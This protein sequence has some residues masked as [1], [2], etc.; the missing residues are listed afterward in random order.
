MNINQKENSSPP[1]SPDFHGFGTDSFFPKPL[2]IETEGVDDEEHVVNIFRRRKAGRPQEGWEKSG[3]IDGL[4]GRNILDEARR[5]PPM[6]PLPSSSV[7]SSPKAV[8]SSPL[9]DKAR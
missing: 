1:S 6:D 2:V 9:T 5:P 4:D 7:S 3:S 8:Q